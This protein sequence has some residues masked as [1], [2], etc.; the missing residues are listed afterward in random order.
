MAA[1]R[2]RSR[3]A[4]SPAALASQVKPTF[5]APA[6]AASVYGGLLARRVLDRGAV[7][8]SLVDAGRRPRRGG[9][10]PTAGLAAGVVLAVA[11]VGPLAASPRRA[12]HVLMAGL[13]VASALLLVAVR[14]L[15]VT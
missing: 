12:V 10:V 8:P 14:G 4:T 1:T 13:A 2:R 7:D 3:P 15:P 11:G 6:L 5:M 9:T